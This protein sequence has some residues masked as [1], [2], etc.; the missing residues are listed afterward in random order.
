VSSDVSPRRRRAVRL[1]FAAVAAL[2]AL[3]VVLL[4]GG[5]GEPYPSILMPAFAGSGGYEAGAVRIERMAPVFISPAGE[6]PVSQRV[7]LGEFPDSHHTILSGLLHPVQQEPRPLQALLRRHLLPG[8]AAGRLDRPTCAQPSLRAWAR[9][10]A[11][12]LL[13][14]VA[15]QR[16]ELRWYRDTFARGGPA[17]ASREPAGTWTIALEDR[18]CAP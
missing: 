16:L 13:P 15:V 8:L 6:H 4:G 2:W 5:A 9:G 12:V 11:A 3:Q 14:G 10:R 18:P 17:P 1:A 7:L